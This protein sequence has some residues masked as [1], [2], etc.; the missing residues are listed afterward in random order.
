M[1]FKAGFW[2][3]VIS[4]LGLEGEVGDFHADEEY[5]MDRWKNIQAGGRVHKGEKVEAMVPIAE[6]V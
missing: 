1:D 5:R 6:H 2:K 4:D 3:E